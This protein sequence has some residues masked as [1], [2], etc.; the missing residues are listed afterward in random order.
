MIDIGGGSTEIMTIEPDGSANEISLPLGAV[1]LTERFLKSDPPAA[2]ELEMIR[3]DVRRSLNE[4]GHRP[5]ARLVGTAGTVATLASMDQKL[6]EYNPDRING[7]VL[8]KNAVKEITRTL[9]I[10]TL[11][12]RRRLQGL[13]PG[14]EDI[15]LAGAIVALEIMD[16]YRIDTMLASD[17]GLREGII[18]D[19]YDKII[20]G[21]S[22]TEAV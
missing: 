16:H 7:Y 1:Y 15:I 14:R 5:V 13:E 2:I 19:L 3:N 22:D 12:E 8:T 17:W 10:S 18:L 9:S 4:A 6:D 11:K 21:R 20:T